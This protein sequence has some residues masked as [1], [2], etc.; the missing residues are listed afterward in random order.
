MSRAYEEVR[1]ARKPREATLRQDLPA[2]VQPAPDQA[3]EDAQDQA[4]ARASQVR[5]GGEGN[6]KR[7]FARTRNL[8]KALGKTAAGRDE[9][10]TG[11]K[12]FTFFKGEDGDKSGA[13]G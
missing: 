1:E 13:R 11:D 9:R 3:G 12:S 4:P 5:Q 7:V 6:M 8:V 2:V 10:R